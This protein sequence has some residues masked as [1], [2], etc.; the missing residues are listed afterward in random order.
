[1]VRCRTF[2]V[3]VVTVFFSNI[4]WFTV[5]SFIWSLSLE[6]W[7]PL[8]MVSSRQ[9]D[10]DPPQHF[11]RKFGSLGDNFC[12]SLFVLVLVPLLYKLILLFNPPQVILISRTRS[13]VQ[14]S[15]SAHLSP[16]KKRR[17]CTF[18]PYILV[19]FHFSPYIL[20]LPLL[21]PKPIN[22]CYFHPFC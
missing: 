17:K 13:T 3:V 18:S 7:C 10:S 16:Q 8:C 5:D 20:I 14:Y 6:V 9:P 12:L 19:F 15:Y 2:N 21:V 1:M 4:S 11:P 22:A